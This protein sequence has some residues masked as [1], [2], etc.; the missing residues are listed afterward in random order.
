MPAADWT[1]KQGMAGMDDREEQLGF[2]LG[3]E[4]KSSGY[5]PNLAHVREDLR[6]ILDQAR[7]AVDAPPWDGRTLR[8]K[9]IVFL[10]MTRWLPS[11]EAEQFC[12]EFL[13]EME[14]IEALLAA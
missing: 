8:Y 5:V 6:S 12:F 4:S 1:R 2:D 11:E 13:R 9:K 14:R 10:Q 3:A 7:A